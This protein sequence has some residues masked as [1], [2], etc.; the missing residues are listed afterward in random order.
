MV[1]GFSVICSTKHKL[2]TQISTETEI[3]AVYDCMHVVLQTRYWFDA[4]GYYVFN[5]ILYQDN[6][7]AIILGKNGRA[8]SMKRTKHI[9]ITYNFV[10]DRI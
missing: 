5:I 3:F 6:K 10:K 4:Q 8:S 1:K 7:S 2:D 9:K